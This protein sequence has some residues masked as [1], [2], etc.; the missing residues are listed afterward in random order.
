[1]IRR[2]LI[3]IAATAAAA[4]ILLWTLSV[5][6]DPKEVEASELI[7]PLQLPAGADLAQGTDD[8]VVVADGARF[9]LK[10]DDGFVDMETDT[11]KPLPDGAARMTNLRARIYGERNRV[12]TVRGDN[13]LIYA[14]DDKPQ[15]GSLEGNVEFR[16]YDDPS[17]ILP[18]SPHERL[19]CFLDEVRFDR[20]L[21]HVESHSPVHLSS[22]RFALSGT[23]LNM[24]YSELDGRIERLS[25]FKSGRL[26]LPPTY[27]HETAA[28][29]PNSSAAS[30]PTPGTPAPPRYYRATFSDN[31]VIRS[32]DTTIHADRL[33][34]VF[35]QERGTSDGSL[36]DRIG[37]TLSPSHRPVGPQSAEASM[38]WSPVP[39]VHS[40]LAATVVQ[41]A[42]A[43]IAL[44]AATDP[45]G[46][47][48]PDSDHDVTITW[49]GRLLVEPVPHDDPRIAL[50]SGPDE[51][52]VTLT[53]QPLRIET[54]RHDVIRASRATY[55]TRHGT[56]ILD[57]TPEGG[58]DGQVKIDSPSMGAQIR[59]PRIVMRQQQRTATVQGPGMIRAFDEP[60]L[61]DAMSPGKTLTGPMRRL[62]A[63]MDI[64][65]TDVL[66]LR[67]FD[68]TGNPAATRTAFEIAALR[69]VRFRGN[70]EVHHPSFDLKSDRLG[71]DLDPRTADGMQSVRRIDANGTVHIV[72]RNEADQGTL[73]LVADELAV[74]LSSRGNGSVEPN[75]IEARGGATP[76]VARYE[77]RVLTAGLLDVMLEAVPVAPPE[78]IRPGGDDASVAVVDMTSAGSYAAE[79]PVLEPAADEPDHQPGPGPDTLQAP[80]TAAEVK[81]GIR[82][83]L[84]E[85]DVRIR[86]PE[87]DA[88]V[89][90]DR[91]VADLAARRLELFG[92]KG[93][94]ARLDRPDGALAG[95]YIEMI[96]ANE[97]VRVIGP[98]QAMFFE[99]PVAMLG[100]EEAPPNVRNAADSQLRAT[101]S[102]S[103]QFDS[104][105]GLAQFVKKAVLLSASETDTAH[106]AADDIRVE[107]SDAEGV[108]STAPAPDR[109][110]A[111]LMGQARVIRSLE[112]VGN[113]VFLSESRPD[114]VLTSS[115]QIKGNLLRFVN[116]TERIQV[117]GPGTLVF[118]DQRPADEA[119]PVQRAAFRGTGKTLFQWQGGLTLDAHHNDMLIRDAV[120]M[121]HLPAG[122][123]ELLMLDCQQLLADLE[124]TG[125]MTAWMG[126]DMPQPD[127]RSVK[128]DHNVVIINGRRKIT[129]DHML[130]THA[131]RLVSLEA[132]AGWSTQIT[133]PP[134]LT[135]RR[136]RWYLETDRFE[137][138]D[139]G[140]GRAGR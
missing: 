30:S 39:S 80:A 12:V 15:N 88:Y 85:R 64:T 63:G 100:H 139:V 124:A 14:P 38:A 115:A 29:E 118:L 86:I 44:Q 94:Q 105:L 58:G 43:A 138:D 83:L 96:E 87:K 21:G 110:P 78:T 125:G 1:M 131:N 4:A 20:E 102:G 81:I 101:W 36:L 99:T 55:Q 2:V 71:I 40:A 10:T 35:A 24:H 126:Q 127:V 62:P 5:E 70:V 69:D 61:V 108:A 22:P 111:D 27:S 13:A 106:L 50:V 56:L 129:T 37:R 128:A 59:A 54:D 25:G 9:T 68:T 132:D 112:A 16:A 116:V 74:H 76:L 122:D 7:V 113:V 95:Q 52:L 31:V 135:A 104:R 67:F 91:V 17:N 89:Q 120:R 79:A 119:P 3:T 77:G 140:P 26:R 23:G 41:A 45:R 84:A 107:F 46:S 34:V 121:T 97:T 114:A 60:G 33:H 98:G 51:A 93:R 65:W 103:M 28:T 136:I 117:E 66:D 90:A 73:D 42:L 8:G 53:G 109:R 137:V 92:S 133:G 82:L 32:G 47:M 18:G 19:R 11:Y 72:A 130:Y 49:S 134:S 123:D 75:R 6:H 48:L 57:Q